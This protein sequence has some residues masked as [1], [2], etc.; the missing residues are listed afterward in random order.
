MDGLLFDWMRKR[1]L[2]TTLSDAEI[3]RRTG[4]AQKR[5][6]YFGVW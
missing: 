2:R 1:K 5:G 4:G 3:E 6:I